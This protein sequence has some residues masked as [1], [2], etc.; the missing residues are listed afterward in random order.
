MNSANPRDRAVATRSGEALRDSAIAQVTQLGLNRDGRRCVDG[1]AGYFSPTGC[2]P[3]SDRG[4]W[5]R[6]DLGTTQVSAPRSRPRAYAA[7]GSAGWT[8]SQ[9]PELSTIYWRCS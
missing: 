9:T 7:P 5:H 2:R 1:V 3:T 6:L 8:L 4:P